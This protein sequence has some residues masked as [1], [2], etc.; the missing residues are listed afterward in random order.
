MES[1]TGARS[2][3]WLMTSSIDVEDKRIRWEFWRKEDSFMLNKAQLKAGSETGRRMH[4]PER[5]RQPTALLFRNEPTSTK[6]KQAK[7]AGKIPMASFFFLRQLYM[8]S[9]CLRDQSSINARRYVTK[10]S[11][12]FFTAVSSERSNTSLCDLMLHH[13]NASVHSTLKIR[14]FLD[15]TSVKLMSYPSYS[16]DGA[17]GQVKLA[18]LRK[19]RVPGPQTQ[20]KFSKITSV[21]KFVLG[22]R[23]Q[24]PQL[25]RVLAPASALCPRALRDLRQRTSPPRTG[26]PCSSLK[27]SRVG[28]A[29]QE[30]NEQGKGARRGRQGY[31]RSPRVA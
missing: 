8:V 21:A 9:V 26:P 16:P 29:P 15:S 30:V 22:L 6:T 1:R 5:K 13:D 10:C 28:R 2:G 14:D 31:G 24:G 27:L 12:E 3:S 4:D 7:S 20:N 11:P 19:Q 25:Q 17:V 23:V 18:R